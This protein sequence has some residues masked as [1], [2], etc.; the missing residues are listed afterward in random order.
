LQNYSIFPELAVDDVTIASGIQITV[1]P[2][3]DNKN[4]AKALLQSI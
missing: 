4:H 3:T 2:T 1:V